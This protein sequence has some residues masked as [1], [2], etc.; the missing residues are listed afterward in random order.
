MEKR[1]T[2]EHETRSW[3][4]SVHLRNEEVVLWQSVREHLLI[5]IINHMLDLKHMLDVVRAEDGETQLTR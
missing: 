4:S 1:T 2:R 3:E 5:E